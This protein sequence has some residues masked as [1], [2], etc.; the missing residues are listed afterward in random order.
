MRLGS[1]LLFL[2]ITFAG[3]SVATAQQAL[4]CPAG[5][6]G[7]ARMCTT[8]H[9]HVQLYRP[10]TKSF[11]DITGGNQFAS[12][13]SCESARDAQMKRNL[14]VVDYFKR[15]KE[16]QY[17]PDRVGPCHC[18]GTIDAANANFLSDVQRK[19][20]LRTREEVRLR[21]REKLLDNNVL[22]D[23]PLVRGLY[24][25]QPPMPA[26][27]TPKLVPMPQTMATPP[28]VSMSDL[29]ATRAIDT[30]KPAAMTVDLPI[31]DV[32]SPTPE[33]SSDHPV[34][35][36]R[37]LPPAGEGSRE[38]TG[39]GLPKPSPSTEITVTETPVVAETTEPE[40]TAEEVASAQETAESFVSYETQRIQNVLTASQSI[41][42]GDL[43]ARVLEACVQRLQV[44]SN[45]RTLIEG[46]GMNSRLANA[47]RV[48]KSENDRVALARRLFGSDITPHWAPKDAA[49]VILDVPPDVTTEP[50]RVLRDSGGKFT[51]QQKKRALYVLL[52][53]TQPTEEQRLWLTTVI[54]AF[55]Q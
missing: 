18:D 40:P 19:A 42:D 1:L 55:L 25:A 38:A 22:S 26:L 9:F 45:L 28:A 24:A 23:S 13:N 7:P 35:S 14:A 50:E 10:D 32:L 36:D 54:N 33:P 6:S 30:S 29:Q 34:P 46:S 15:V 51:D 31:V 41:S 2:A 12:E 44:L 3:P 27:A 4:V 39:E 21:V 8:F 11:V 52:A 37:A 49:D 16:Q 48:A 20:Q 53:R 43:Q 5:S 17:E 47:A